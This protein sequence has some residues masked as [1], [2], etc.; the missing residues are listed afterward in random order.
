[1]SSDLT[2]LLVRSNSSFIVKK[3]APDVILSREPGNLLNIH[4]QALSPLANDKS[5]GVDA[6]EN[7][8]A[9]VTRDAT[10]NPRGVAK[11]MKTVNL[12]R[13]TS[14]RKAASIASNAASKTRPDLR[15]A[16]VARA[17]TLVKN[18]KAPKAPKSNRR[19]KKASA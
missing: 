8:V 2:W 9:I 17:T 19:S 4:A 11:S 3:R 18:T 16:A 14:A 5:I 10:K 1:M 6:H 15:S 12:K 13:G 7:G